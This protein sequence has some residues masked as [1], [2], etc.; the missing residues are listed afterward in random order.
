ME[1]G[2]APWNLEGCAGLEGGMGGRFREILS[3]L[4]QKV[5]MDGF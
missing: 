2:L 5:R 1:S 3:L 4:R